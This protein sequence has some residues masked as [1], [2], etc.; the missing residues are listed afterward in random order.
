MRRLFSSKQHSIMFLHVLLIVGL[1]CLAQVQAEQQIPISD[2]RI[3]GGV[4]V[5]ITDYPYQVSLQYRR[6]HM[7]GGSIVGPTWVITAAHCTDR[8]LPNMLGVRVGSSNSKSGG[9]TIKVKKIHQHPNY[10][11]DIID[12]DISILELASEISHPNAKPIPLAD[13]SLKIDSGLPATITGWGTTSEGGSTSPY[14]Q[15][16]QVPTITQEKCKDKYKDSTIT[17]RMF[18]AG[19][20]EGGKDSCQGDSGG[21][22]I[23]NG[24]LTGVVSWGYG[25]ARPNYPGVY[26][27]IP[28]LREHIEKVMGI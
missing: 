15:M 19:Y 25:C 16:V 2:H 20:D 28:A 22:L 26:S 23:I 9:Q 27:S 11:R 17:D 14:L 18:C 1:A 21:P 24:K 8:I 7:C 10:R 12:Y 4:A 3:V 6:N 13:G 5:N